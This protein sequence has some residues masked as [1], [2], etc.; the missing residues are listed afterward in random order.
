MGNRLMYDK[1]KRGGVSMELS[2]A[3]MIRL[4]AKRKGVTVGFIADGLGHSRQNLSNK[5]RKNEFKV[6]ELEEIATAVG[7]RVELH[8]VDNKTGNR[9]I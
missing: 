4:L 7:A 6:S 1:A 9:I 2:V 3:E 8:F 5:L